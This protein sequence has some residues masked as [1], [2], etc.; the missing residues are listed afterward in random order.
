VW[1]KVFVLFTICVQKRRFVMMELFRKTMLAS[2]GIA[3]MTA[4]R[5]QELG[6]RL[7]EESQSSQEE[8]RKFID[9]L[10]KRS[11]ETRGAMERMVSQRVEA[12]L[13][14]MNLPTRKQVQDL[15]AQLGALGARV[16]QLEKMVAE[17]K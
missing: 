2:V 3:F 8:A 4:E 7:A 10:Q 15:E 14:G 12:M 16:A 13:E 11:G 6:K 17:K 1:D 9:E 5:V